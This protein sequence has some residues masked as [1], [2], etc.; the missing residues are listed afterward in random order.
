M[1]AKKNKIVEAKSG[2]PTAA[3]ATA[4]VLKGGP[5]KYRE[6]MIF[7]EK[8]VYIKRCKCNSIDACIHYWSVPQ[9][10]WESMLG[11]SWTEDVELPPAVAQMVKKRERCESAY[12]KTLKLIAANLP[13]KKRRMLMGRLHRYEN[14]YFHTQKDFLTMIAYAKGAHDHGYAMENR[15]REVENHLKTVRW[16]EWSQ[17][18][19]N[20]TYL[21]NP[22]SLELEA[23][24]A[25]I[26]VSLHATNNNGHAS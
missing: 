2:A 21:E 12:N 10:A 11:I 4:A 9:V 16:N 6:A 1:S 20:K 15:L 22:Y 7:F 18:L 13:A 23:Q 24:R 8:A 26:C 5:G 25:G 14:E 17:D 19:Y 3:D